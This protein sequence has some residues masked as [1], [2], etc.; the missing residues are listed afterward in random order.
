VVVFLDIFM[1]IYLVLFCMGYPIAVRAS[2][3]LSWFRSILVGIAGF[4]AFQGFEFAFI[5]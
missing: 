5:R 2:T 1:A 3:N 4:A